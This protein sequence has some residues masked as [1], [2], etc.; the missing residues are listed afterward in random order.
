MH[1]TP[2]II[3]HR[4][5]LRIEEISLAKNFTADRFHT[6]ATD[7]EVTADCCAYNEFI[8]LTLHA[9]KNIEIKNN[10][11]MY[12]KKSVAGQTL[13]NFIERLPYHEGL[14][15]GVD[16]RIIIA[17]FDERDLF[18]INKQDLTTTLKDDLIFLSSESVIRSL[19][20]HVFM[21]V[22]CRINRLDH[23]ETK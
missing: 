12:A 16:E 14:A 17:C 1:W 2:D 23:F 11:A 5:S 4:F 22:C 18:N 15:A 19:R 10:R 8:V 20:D 6:M 21:I 3:H 13:F 7:L 9:L